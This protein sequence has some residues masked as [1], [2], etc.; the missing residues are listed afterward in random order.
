MRIAIDARMMS[1]LLTRGIGR[2]VEELIRAMLEQLGSQ[3]RFVLLVRQPEN[4]PFLHHPA[5]EHQKADI[6]WYSFQEQVQMPRLLRETHADLVH[7]PHW[8]APLFYRGPLILTIHD[9]ILRHQA[10]SAKASTRHPLFAMMKRVGY[11]LLLRDVMQKGKILLVPTQFVAQDVQALYPFTKDKIMVTG[12]GISEFPPEDD[13]F[14][15]QNPYLF[16]VGS[17]YPHKRLD[18]LLE[19][20]QRLSSRYPTHELLIAGEEDV[21]MARHV[22]WVSQH[23]L[24]RVRFL[25]RVSDA[26]LAAL[27]HHATAFVFPSSD[28]GMGLPPLEALAHGTP[29]ISSDSS[30]LPEVLRTEGVFFF[31]NGD[32]NGM[33]QAIDAVLSDPATARQRAT[34]AQA[35]LRGRYSWKQVAERTLAAYQRIVH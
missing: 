21:F 7:V 30:C 34:N 33:I 24:A 29:V 15:P 31:R 3:D 32:V 23:Q 27:H 10:A 4:S 9:L 11:R 17:A 5:V 12:E 26:E 13:H 28:E 1:P 16:Y 2:Y 20:W 8:N 18:V 25:G 6:Q 14:V 19:A 35:S 22:A